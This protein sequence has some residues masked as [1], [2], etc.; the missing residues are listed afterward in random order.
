MFPFM[1]PYLMTHAGARRQRFGEDNDA[2]SFGA[3]QLFGADVE[4]A[5]YTPDGQP[6]LRPSRRPMRRY[7]THKSSKNKF[8]LVPNNR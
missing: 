8:I 3:D 6:V 1:L 5:G 2:F 7:S 4:L